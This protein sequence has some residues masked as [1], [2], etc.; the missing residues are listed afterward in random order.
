M[1]KDARPATAADTAHVV[2]K[3]DYMPNRKRTG[4]VHIYTGDG[5]GKTSTSLGLGLRASGHGLKVLMIQFLKG[6]GH[7]GEVEAVKNIPD[8]TIRQF[9]KP[10]PYSE[11]MRK[12][13]MECGNCKDCFLTRAEEKEKVNEALTLAEKMTTTNKYDVIILDE[14]NNVLNRKLAPVSRVKKLIKKRKP[15]IELILTGRNAP[16]ELID[17][18]DYITQLKK[19]KHPFTKGLRARYG[20]DY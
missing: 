1:K 14:I 19:I 4:L 16:P 3:G 8:F 10:C 18:A 5:K 13:S 9:G 2:Y 15:H 20:I 6:G 7:V 11:E 17:D 12:G